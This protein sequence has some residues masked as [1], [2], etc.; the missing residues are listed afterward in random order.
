M[1][2]FDKVN[3]IT[4]LMMGIVSLVMMCIVIY[5]VT[6]RYIFNA[7]TLW[8]MEIN[9]YLFCAMSL[10]A[11]GYCLLRDGHVRVDVLYPKLSPKA[12]AITDFCTFPLALLFCGLLIWFG[13]QETWDSIVGNR[14]SDSVL[15]LPLWPVWLTVPV[16]GLLMGIQVISRLLGR[17]ED[18]KSSGEG[19]VS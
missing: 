1:N 6:S 17:I 5:E 4:G 10:L 18:L 15:A 2:A 12:L 9:Q 16:A 19:N 3:G 13:L 7:P 11:G 14:L 8:A